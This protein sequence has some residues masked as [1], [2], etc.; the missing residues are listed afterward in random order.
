MPERGVGPNRM[1]CREP[2]RRRAWLALSALGLAVSAAAAAWVPLDNNDVWIHLTTGRLILQERAVPRVD[3]YSFTAAGNRYVAHEWLADVGY[4]LGERVAGAAGVVALAKLLPALALVAALL[5]ALGSVRAPPGL[6][7]PLAPLA[8]CVLRRRISARPEL[9]ALPLLLGAL[10]LLWRDREAASDGRRTRALWLLVPLEIVWV[11]LHGSFP[12]GVALVLV[13]ALAELGERLLAARDARAARARAAAVAAGLAGAAA[14]ATRDP[15]AFAVPAAAL[16]AAGSL[17]LAADATRP[18]FRVRPGGSGQGVGRLLALAAL[19]SAGALVNPRGVELLSFPFEFT[20]GENLITTS[21]NEWKPLFAA[22]HLAGSLAL[23]AW[24]AFSALWCGA[25]ALGARRAQLGLLELGL[26]LGLG[27]LPLL[28]ARWM[29][30]FALASA[31]ALAS[32]LAAARAG[33]PSRSRPGLVGALALAAASAA[34]LARAAA[35]VA[36]VPVDPVWIAALGLAIAAAA[37]GFW[38]AAL[39]SRPLHAGVVAAAVAAA[40][41]ALLSLSPGIPDYAGV[42]PR[43]PGADAA[44][45]GFGPSLHGRAATDFLR[46]S[47]VRGRLFTEYEWAGYAIHTLWP[48]VRVFLDSRSEVYGESLLAA[49]QGAKR[50]RTEAGVVLDHF[51]V[52][53]VLVRHHPYPL[54]RR[55]NPGVLGAVQAHPSWR[56]LYVD[57]RALVY[58]RSVPGRTLPA[59]L[60]FAPEAFRL[61]DADAARPERVR[62]LRNAVERA[63]DSSFLRLALAESLRLQRRPD[64]ALAELAAGWAANPHYAPT[65]QLAG[66]IAAASGR[67][68]QARRWFE[69]ALALAPGWDRAQRA[70]ET[71]EP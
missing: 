66:E 53:L 18:L 56:L 69:R 51:G 37:A 15:V 60:A 40:G 9:L 33:S 19:M 47:A 12:L 44:G 70:L 42:P 45:P 2:L 14:L 58:A 24:W 28:H 55:T 23:P 16:L 21:V 41:L 31:P 6:A 48:A 1:D 63:P 4:A 52:D 17:L 25:L 64:E 35:S 13:F 43:R 32:T 57:D 68:E 22:D 26:G 61:A 65:A 71:V 49:Y 10:W 5:L 3:R 39:P 29:G 50:S 59:P 67:R 46:R 11:N 7:L 8:L 20:A 54:G 36:G 27:A 30:L 38:L 34:C 62:A